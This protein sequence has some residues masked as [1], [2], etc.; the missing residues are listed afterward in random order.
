MSQINT[1]QT[2]GSQ[3][4]RHW[5]VIAESGTG[6]GLRFLSTIHG[7]FG[8]RV[9]SI[10]L[11]PAIAYF[12]LAKPLARRSSKEFLMTHRAA[13]PSVWDHPVRRRDVL[14]HLY[15]FGQSVLD[16]ALAWTTP[17]DE[18]L[19]D[20]DDLPALEAFLARQ[21]GQ[22]I[23]GSHFGNLEFCRGFVERYKSK[24]INIL[25]YDRHSANF[26]KVMSEKSPESRVHVYQVD[27]LDIPLILRL[28]EKLAAGEWC[29]IAGD[30]IPLS[31]ETRTTKV[32]FLNRQA[33]L[34]IGPYLLAKTLECEVQLMFSYRIKERIRFVRVPFAKKITI[35]R[36]ARDADLQAYA[37]S[38]ADALAKELKCAPYQWFNFYD[39]FKD[40]GENISHTAQTKN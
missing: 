1:S 19:F 10:L 24:T 37:Q 11:T 31:G 38:Y 26:I 2:D 16:K 13:F 25:V 5:S 39:Y 40:L 18:T 28:K 27:E 34:P 29:F 33:S 21:D 15:A 8:R 30:R 22:L 14:K 32:N 12:Y 6:L 9:F 7:L 35:N 17:I 4:T 3:K 23:I 36:R 20:I